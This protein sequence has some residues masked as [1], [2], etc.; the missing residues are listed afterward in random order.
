MILVDDLIATGAAEAPWLL[1]Q[2]GRRCSPPVSS[3][4]RARRRRKLRKDGRA[5]ADIDLVR[6]TDELEERGIAPFRQTE[7]QQSST[8]NPVQ[9]LNIPVMWRET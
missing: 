8:Q 9:S 1:R 2:M 5:S 4:M 3:S 7:C 6:G